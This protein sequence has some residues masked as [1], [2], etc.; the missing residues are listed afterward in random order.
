MNKVHELFL[1]SN[2]CR[3]LNV[4]WCLLGN[5]LVSEFYIPTF[6]NTLSPIHRWA[7]RYLPTCEDGIDRR[8]GITQTKVYYK[9]HEVDDSNS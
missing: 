3:V 8:W 1:I 2:F 7:G 6:W 5:S 9:V 4:V